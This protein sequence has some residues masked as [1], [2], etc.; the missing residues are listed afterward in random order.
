MSISK[1]SKKCN[2]CKKILNVSNF[3]KSYH[4]IRKKYYYKS[5]C[6]KCRL[7]THKKYR[8]N[9][10]LTTN[11]KKC[12]KCKITKTET[13][14]YKVGTFCKECTKLD[15]KEDY[16]KNKDKEINYFIICN[17]CGIEKYGNN[18]RY[19]R[20]KCINCEKKYGRKYNKENYEIRKKWIKN[21]KEKIIKYSINRR[22]PNDIKKILSNYNYTDK[23]LKKWIEYNFTEEMNWENHGDVWHL[24]HTLPISKF[25]NKDLIIIN[26]WVNLIPLYKRDNLRKSNRI[27][28][29][30]IFIL[31]KKLREF[32]YIEQIDI[33]DKIILIKNCFNKVK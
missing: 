10:I 15:R 19:N 25:K 28:P 1:E 16:K 23:I 14:F 22:I 24:D 2:K 27:C 3:D 12:S 8:N 6:K 30:Y 31:E 4:N 32:C 33:E 5:E 17:C 18:F 26:D 20:K 11:E 9:K 13:S 21:N 29:F 7:E